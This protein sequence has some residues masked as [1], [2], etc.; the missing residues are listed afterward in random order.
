MPAKAENWQ[1]VYQN[2]FFNN[3]NWTTNDSAGNY[4]NEAGQNYHTQIRDG[5]GDY[6]Y[7]PISLNQNNSYKLEFDLSVADEEAHGGDVRFGL[8]DSAMDVWASTTFYVDYWDAGGGSEWYR[9][10]VLGEFYTNDQGVSYSPSFEPLGHFFTNAWYHNVLI[11]DHA[12]QTLS[13]TVTNS[14]GS[15]LGTQFK[16]GVGTFTGM[17]RLYISSIGDNNYTMGEGYID[18][19]VVSATPEPASMILLGLGGLFIKS[20]AAKRA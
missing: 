17:D 7:T 19:V 5:Y 14:D 3:P 13:L 11:Y 4:W 8:S 1:V 10:S 15:I 12:A 16:T 6:A 9:G 20:R 2:D 18:N